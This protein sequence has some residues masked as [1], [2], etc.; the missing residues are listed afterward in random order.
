MFA[1]GRCRI[2]G[3]MDGLHHV[4]I[5]PESNRLAQVGI[6]EAFLA[7]IHRHSS[8]WPG[9]SHDIIGWL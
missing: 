3:T 9:I 6:R 2:N 1:A 7:A 8:L 5:C 4:D